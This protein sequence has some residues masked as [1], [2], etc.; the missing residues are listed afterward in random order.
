[1][2]LKYFLAEEDLDNY[3]AKF[4]KINEKQKGVFTYEFLNDGN[5]LE[6]LK[7]LIYLNTKILIHLSNKQIFLLMNII[8]V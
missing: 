1:L 6:E 5:Y 3:A 8:F 4:A 7:N 2:D